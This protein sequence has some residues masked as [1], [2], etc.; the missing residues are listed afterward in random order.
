MAPRDFCHGLLIQRFHHAIQAV[1]S[2]TTRKQRAREIA[3]LCGRHQ[4]PAGAWPAGRGTVG[5]LLARRASSRV[6]R[7]IAQTI[8]QFFRTIFHKIS[9]KVCVFSSQTRAGILVAGADG[10]GGSARGCSSAAGGSYHGTSGGGIAAIIARSG[11]TRPPHLQQ[12]SSPSSSTSIVESAQ[13]HS[14]SGRRDFSP[15]A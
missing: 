4:A 8:E 7:A 11:G 10:W 1:I 15:R 3:P 14:K 2:D 5:F 6:C 9:S 12:K 13:R